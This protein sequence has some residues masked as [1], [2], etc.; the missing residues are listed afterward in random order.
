[1]KQFRYLRTFESFGAGPSPAPARP[2]RRPAPGTKPGQPNT[3]P[4][5]RPSRKSP[6][7]KPSVAP[8][9]KAE[10][11]EVEDVITHFYSIASEEMKNQI[12]NHY[13]K[14]DK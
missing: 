1:M 3:D 2:Q 11:A 4:G 5:K 10:I 9:P 13:A 12:N 7:I 14:R 8:K 6:I